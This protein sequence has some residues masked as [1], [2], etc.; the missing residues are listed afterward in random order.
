MSVGQ[1]QSYQPIINRY[2]AGIW[3]W[4]SVGLWMLGSW[5]I[6]KLSAS[7]QQIFGWVGGYFGLSVRCMLSV[8]I[9]SVGMFLHNT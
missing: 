7:A 3:E 1:C 5:S 9:E 2:M 6:P 4:S 8:G